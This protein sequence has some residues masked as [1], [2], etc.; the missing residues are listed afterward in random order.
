VEMVLAVGLL[1]ITILAVG[2]LSLTIIRSNT[3][4]N[5]RTTTAAVTST[6]LERVLSQ[7][8]KDSAFWDQDHIAT[9]Y[10]ED[11]VKMG[12]LEYDYAVYAETVLDPSGVPVGD[13]LPN[14][15]LK[16]VTIRVTWFDT[17]TSDRQGYGEL[18]Q[19]LTR[20]VNEDG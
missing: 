12:K 15:R 18:S 2:L 16:R 17:K 11:K 6:L 8:Q 3:E 14:N 9:P 10:V 5:D 20:V 4:S 1:A 7:A 13:A 19:T